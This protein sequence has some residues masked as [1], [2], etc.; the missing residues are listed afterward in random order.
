MSCEGIGKSFGE[1]AK[2]ID[3]VSAQIDDAVDKTVDSIASELGI[4]AL[5]AKFALMQGEIEAAFQNEFPNL[6]SFFAELKSGIPF[7][8]ELGD[9]IKVISQAQLAADKI[10]EMKD[11]YGDKDN[12][13]NEILRDPAG[14]IETLGGDLESLCESMP[15]Y[16][17]AKDGSIKVT[18]AKFNFPDKASIDIEEI[19]N[20]GLSPTIKNIED[21]IKNL[22]FEIV[23]KVTTLNKDLASP[24]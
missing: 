1:L 2:Q 13:I 9:I 23:P 21:V 15:N 17:K 12:N 14:F 19:M 24:Y 20:E 4:N 18:S 8:T 10:Q 3:E 11:K 7:A 6:D 5:K 16:Q 22:R